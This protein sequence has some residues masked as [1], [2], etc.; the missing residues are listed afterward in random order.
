MS[1]DCFGFATDCIFAEES[2]S[3]RADDRYC[4]RENIEK[5]DPDCKNC[6][7][8]YSIDMARAMIQ[9]AQEF[10]KVDEDE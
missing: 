6:K 8:Y 5:Y 1:I 7:Y 3:Q 9:D 2:H 10:W 4:C